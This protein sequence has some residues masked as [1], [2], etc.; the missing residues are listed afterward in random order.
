MKRSMLESFSLP[1][2]DGAALTLKEEHNDFL[3][4]EEGLS[5]DPKGEYIL[6]GKGTM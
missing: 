3:L 6:V 5:T 1:G 2:D 4:T